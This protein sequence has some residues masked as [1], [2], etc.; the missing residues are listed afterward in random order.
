MNRTELDGLDREALIRRA[1][2]QGVA[3]AR[4][5]T[6]PELIDEIV[7]RSAPRGAAVA[8]QDLRRARGFFGLARDLLARVVERG[9]HLPDA[10]ER[11]RGQKSELP[12]RAGGPAPVL[13]TVTLAE[14][15]AT[16][17]HKERAIETLHKV[18]EAE[19]DHVAA[20]AL[21]D[22]LE[23]PS[24]KAPEPPLPPEEEPS[25]ARAAEPE[26]E[27]AEPMGMLDDRPLP[28]RYDANECVAIPVDPGTLF[29]YWE[30]KESLLET[31]RLERPEGTIALRV[32]IVQPGWSGP[33]T[34]VRD[35][36][37]YS[38]L[39]DYFLYDLPASVVVRVAVGWK[40]AEGFLPIA[41]SPALDLPR[42]GPDEA[43]ARTFVRWTPRGAFPVTDDAALAST[44]AR[45]VERAE[46]QLFGPGP[47]APEPAPAEEPLGSSE[48]ML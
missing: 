40:S 6:R 23:E 28:L 29:V 7:V 17:G 19:P 4:I 20:K 46:A 15:Y 9:L 11:I 30:V 47:A 32:L 21:L 18:L 26:E 44:I 3:R 2:E 5:L 31:V 16:Q 45:A 43:L 39:G 14:I 37:V 42:G 38:T 36:E 22:R 1:E 34:S 24:Y 8:E 41:H 12:R 25:P 10:A 35:H 48:N 33:R 27:L 13:P